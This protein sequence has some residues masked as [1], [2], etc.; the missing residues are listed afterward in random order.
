MKDINEFY[1]EVLESMHYSVDDEG[2]ISTMTPTG[3]AK[4]ATI[5]GMRLVLPTKE[6]LKKGFGEDYQPFHPLSEAI[7]RRGTSPV[8]QHMQRNAR[9]QLAFVFVTLATELL[10]V[11]ADQSLHKD[12]PPSCS[13]FLRKL[14]NADKK[15][16]PILDNLIRAAT[17]KNRLITVFLKNGGQID[18]K[19]VNRLCTIRFPIIEALDGEDNNVLGVEIRP[20]QRQAL[21]NLLR[22]IV[23]LGDSP[24]E[25][26]AGSNNRVAP[27]LHAFLQAYHKIASQ[28]DRII[29]RYGKPMDLPIKSFKLYPVESL[30]LFSELYD[31]V[32]V[33][34]GNQGE[35]EE[36]VEE[37]V[38]VEGKAK[39]AQDV[40]DAMNK[41]PVAKPATPAASASVTVVGGEQQHAQPARAAAASS[42]PEPG[43]ISI[44]D[45]MDSMRPQQPA[46]S[47]NGV[48][49]VGGMQPST[50]I[51]VMGGYPV[52]D[53]LRPSWL[54]GNQPQMQQQVHPF[55]SAMATLTTAPAPVTPNYTA[56]NTQGYTLGGVQG[57]AANLGYPGHQVGMNHN[58]L[59]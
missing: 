24:E 42:A 13:D 37:E 51:P 21:S 48:S 49:I 14:S 56:V 26:S 15:L 45:L 5:E 27:Y 11:A 1:R 16:L 33:L 3:T 9:A 38:P 59:L 29:T 54:V 58:P 8:L 35:V 46:M 18:G 19:K 41:P 52:Q 53:P 34:R 57:G 32:P 2:L 31:Q 25:Y 44:R 23:P 50:T 36:T 7:S 6:W 55:A 10:K 47:P 39:S 4:A 28:L 30:D 43:T 40:F 22:L 12:L 20:K 17:K